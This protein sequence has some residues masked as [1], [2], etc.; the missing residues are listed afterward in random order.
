MTPFWCN[1]WGTLKGGGNSS[2]SVEMKL[3]YCQH[4]MK[5]SIGDSRSC[6]VQQMGIVLSVSQEMV[7]PRALAE[8]ED[9][10]FS[11]VQYTGAL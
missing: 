10:F 8:L 5:I 6:M 7:F 2:D 9:S 4:P 11:I 3:L 1:H